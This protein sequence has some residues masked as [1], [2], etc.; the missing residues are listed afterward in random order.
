MQL[1]QCAACERIQ[2]LGEKKFSRCGTC[3]QTSY[4]SRE[5]QAQ[6]WKNG[7]KQQCNRQPEQRK[8]ADNNLSRDSSQSRIYTAKDD[9]TPFYFNNR[10]KTE[11]LLSPF[12]ES[13]KSEDQTESNILYI[14]ESVH[15]DILFQCKNGCEISFKMVQ[16]QQ[17]RRPDSYG[18]RCIECDLLLNVKSFLPVTSHADHLRNIMYPYFNDETETP[19]VICCSRIR[20]YS[21]GNVR[22]CH[23]CRKLPDNKVVSVCQECNLNTCLGCLW[24]VHQNRNSWTSFFYNRPYARLS[25]LT[26]DATELAA[27]SKIAGESATSKIAGESATPA[28]T[29][30]K[31]QQVFSICNGTFQPE[32]QIE[33]YMLFID[34]F[35]VTPVLKCVNGC[36]SSF[37]SVECGS[38]NFGVMCA[39]CFSLLVERSSL[40]IVSCRTYL[41]SCFLSDLKKTQVSKTLVEILQCSS[42]GLKSISCG[43][44]R[45]CR[46]CETYPDNMVTV[47]CQECDVT[48]CVPCLLT[49]L[50][51]ESANATCG[52]SPPKLRIQVSELEKL[53][54]E[55]RT[56]ETQKCAGC[57]HIRC[58][59][60]VRFKH[61]SACSHSYYCSRECQMH[62]WKNGHKQNCR[63]KHI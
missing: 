5:C 21:V 54:N 29:A 18:L 4:C 14:D 24:G 7:H 48:E 2:L 60:E 63:T 38:D 11:K 47:F 3:G 9:L 57:K 31:Q 19:S 33:R 10:V 40:P 1:R 15:E 8:A 23:V 55:N 17:P 26:E 50:Q 41:K 42:H 12:D 27:T 34:D 62:D 13:F 43:N 51:E 36:A 16:Y 46:E 22:E 6:H 25:S 56:A 52:I 37:N 59:G 45:K 30:A 53:F 39:K 32:D 35:V 20:I 28:I 61:C 49:L 58:L 44:S